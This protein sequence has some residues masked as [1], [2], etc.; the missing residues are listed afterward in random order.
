MPR[1]VANHPSP[2]TA[3]LRPP[4][5]SLP[6]LPSNRRKIKPASAQAGAVSVLRAAP[7]KSRQSRFFP[8]AP[9]RLPKPLL[10]R[11][12]VPDRTATAP[13]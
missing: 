11:P 7:I 8:S 5:Q 13:G 3:P 6:Q 1:S 2:A 10:R 9:S 4:D 12:S